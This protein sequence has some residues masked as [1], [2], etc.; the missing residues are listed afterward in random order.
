MTTS[1]RSVDD[2]MHQCQR[3]GGGRPVVQHDQGVYLAH[4]PVL[5]GQLV[6]RIICSYGELILRL[7]I[8]SSVDPLIRASEGS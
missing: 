6:S 2:L 8:V 7:L 5:P 1:G 3:S 4:L